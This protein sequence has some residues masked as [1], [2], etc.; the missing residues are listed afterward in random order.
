MKSF[1]PPSMGSAFRFGAVYGG[2]VH[3]IRWDGRALCGVSAR[4]VER[5]PIDEMR[6]GPLTA[7]HCSCNR[8]RRM[9]RMPKWEHA[10]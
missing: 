9:L 10:R 2:E 1:H 5:G 8:C 7:D 4:P 6:H 3:A